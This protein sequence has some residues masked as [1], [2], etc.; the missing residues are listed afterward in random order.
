[1]HRAVPTTSLRGSWRLC[2]VSWGGTGIPGEEVT[3]APRIRS[4]LVGGG[5][6]SA[7]LNSPLRRPNQE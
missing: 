2:P 3:L 4:S 1:M 6:L 7:R 5:D